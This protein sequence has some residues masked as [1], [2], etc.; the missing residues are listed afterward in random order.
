[1][2]WDHSQTA[3]AEENPNLP[4]AEL[5]KFALKEWRSLGE[6]KKSEWNEKAK[7]ATGSSGSGDKK[8][9]RENEEIDENQTTKMQKQDNLLKKIESDS[10]CSSTKLAG[11]AFTKT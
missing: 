2:W 3:I 11:F 9:K 1:M 8:R 6:D 7:M 10:V 5:V 4:E